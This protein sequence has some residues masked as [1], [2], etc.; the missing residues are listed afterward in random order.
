MGTL[1][2]IQFAPTYHD[3]VLYNPSES[4]DGGRK[5][6][7]RTFVPI[8]PEMDTARRSKD[9]IVNKLEDVQLPSLSSS[10]SSSSDNS[11]VD[12]PV[13]SEAANSSMLIDASSTV[14]LPYDLSL[15]D[16][17]MANYPAKVPAANED[18][19]R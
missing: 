19:T 3:Y 7:S 12:R 1:V 8:G 2:I 16:I 17:E 5:Y 15:I 4:E 10:G 9:A 14:S 13:K 18:G 11:G 6:R